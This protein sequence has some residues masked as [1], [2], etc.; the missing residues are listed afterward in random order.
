[1]KNYQDILGIVLHFSDPSS[2]S[3]LITETH[4]SQNIEIS[5]DKGVQVCIYPYKRSKSVR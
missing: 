3:S 4:N 2:E 5:N 1:M